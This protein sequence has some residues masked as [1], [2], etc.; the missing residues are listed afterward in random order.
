MGSSGNGE[1]ADC[2]YVCTIGV[3]RSYD[4]GSAEKPMKMEAHWLRSRAYKG[5][6]VM[7]V[8]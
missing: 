5:L 1:K 6:R 8:V 3:L 2:L 7:L 4:R